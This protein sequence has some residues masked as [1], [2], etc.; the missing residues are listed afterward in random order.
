MRFSLPSENSIGATIP[1]IRL[2]GRLSRRLP[3]LLDGAPT[4]ERCSSPPGSTEFN[5]SGS[6][7]GV[8]R[9]G[10]TS[11]GDRLGVVC[12]GMAIWGEAKA[13]VRGNWW[14]LVRRLADKADDDEIAPRASS[15]KRSL[16]NDLAAQRAT[17]ECTDFFTQKTKGYDRFRGRLNERRPRRVL[18]PGVVRHTQQV[19]DAT[20]YVRIGG[21]GKRLNVYFRPACGSTVFWKPESCPTVP[22]GGLHFQRA[23]R[24]RAQQLLLRLVKV[25][26]APARER[27]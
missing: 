12:E 9:E 27:S 24:Q 4:S 1:E 20:T 16:A 5:D 10:S 21:R 23:P 7:T 13:V 22:T 11:S 26:L 15:I 2:S 25:E 17:L 8:S 6:R 19:G 3:Q 18:I 14:H